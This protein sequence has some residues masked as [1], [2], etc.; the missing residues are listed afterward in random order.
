VALETILVGVVVALLFIETSGVWPGGIVV[1]GYLALNLDHPERVLAT[2]VAAFLALGLY[3]LIS[4]YLLLFGR[5]RF[6][7][8]LL[9]GTAGAAALTLF[10]PRLGFGPTELRV[11]GWVIPGLLANQLGRQKPLPTL[12]GLAVC[13]IATHFL[14]RLGTA[15]FR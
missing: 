5:R 9:L 15:I 4:R 11:V 14:V 7:V 12:A 6:V 3:R 13:V 1:P 10:W 2:L 8:M